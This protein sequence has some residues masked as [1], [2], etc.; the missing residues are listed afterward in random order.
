MYLC[1]YTY[2]DTC[3]GAH[4][5]LLSSFC[6]SFFK[7]KPQPHFLFFIIYY[8]ILVLGLG[9]FSGLMGHQLYTKNEGFLNPS[10]LA[11]MWGHS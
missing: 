4:K 1:H 11:L 9:G 10:G 6:I 7:V 5:N 3:T 8:E 2:V